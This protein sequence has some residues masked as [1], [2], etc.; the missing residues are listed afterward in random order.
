METTAALNAYEINRD[1]RIGFWAEWEFNTPPD[2]RSR[3]PLF[4]ELED[5][6]RGAFRPYAGQEGGY[7]LVLLTRFL[8]QIGGRFIARQVTPLMTVNLRLGDGAPL[9]VSM[10]YSKDPM[11]GYPACS[12]CHGLGGGGALTQEAGVPSSVL[13]LHPR[14]VRSFEAPQFSRMRN[15]RGG[16]IGSG[17]QR[18]EGLQEITGP[19]HQIGPGLFQILFLG[20]VMGFGSKI[21]S[22]V[23]ANHCPNAWN[24][25]VKLAEIQD[26]ATWKYPDNV[27]SETTRLADELGVDP[28]KPQEHAGA[29]WRQPCT[30]CQGLGFFQEP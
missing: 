30:A 25:P 20:S 21:P 26:A 24:Y 17:L 5:A 29:P 13:E 11:R 22:R 8:K 10:S 6:I 12:S 16:L 28:N 18:M 4:Q 3:F 23:A 15:H 7:R 1:L 9:R 27:V 14:M 2:D 19:V